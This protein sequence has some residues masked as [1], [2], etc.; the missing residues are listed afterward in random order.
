MTRLLGA[1]L[2][3]IAG[4]RLVRRTVLLVGL[5]IALGGILA[6]LTTG[7]LSEATY[8]RRVRAADV[9]QTAQRARTQAC[10]QAHGVKEGDDFSNEIGAACVPNASPVAHDPRF[11]RARLQ[12]LLQGVAG[13][14]AIIGWA[15]GASLIGAEFASRSMTTLLTWET[16]R[17][18]VIVAKTAVVLVTVAAFAA[19]TL[20]AVAVVLLPTLALH[21]APLRAGDPTPA[22]LA[23]VIGRGTLLAAVAAGMGFALAALGRNTAAALGFGFAYIIVLENIL[24]NSLRH[25]RR[26]LLLGNAIVFVSGHAGTD[27]PGR[28]VAGAGLLLAAVAGTLLIGAAVAFRMRDIA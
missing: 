1:E 15:L 22:T 24:G 19:V 8:Q 6:F 12:S 10:L 27:I 28:S 9:A 14:V 26:W 3:R 4:R 5:A 23:G 21:G 18:R 13:V 11:H 25:W 17:T 16:R 20:V 7:S 2:R